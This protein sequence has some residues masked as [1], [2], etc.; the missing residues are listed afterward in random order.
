[1]NSVLDDSKLLTL[2]NGDRV[3]LTTTVR[4]LFEVQDLAVASPATV[5][6]A[7]M[8]YMDIEELGWKPFFEQWIVSKKETHGQDFADKLTELT[9][10]WLIKVLNI[11]K[12][13][14]RE[15]V[16]T[17]ENACTRSLSQLF[18]ACT[19]SLEKGEEESRE[20][21]LNYIEKWFVFAMI[22]SVGA[23]VDE[24]SRKDIDNVMRDI[25]AM[26]PH[27]NTV[28]EYYINEQKKDWAPWE[29]KL[30]SVIKPKGKEFH[31]IMV[32]TVDTVRNRYIC[33]RLVE[34]DS[35]ILFIG[36]SGVGKT[37]LIDGV[38]A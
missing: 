2:T 3:A 12:T 14:C 21:F 29:E 13:M 18:D 1:M 23:T 5:S 28:F 24:T 16:A 8:I 19:K 34:R 22:W 17:S 32:H 6:R 11:K 33:E 37:V 38:L 36:E 27:T 26:F 10:K 4:L 25:E 7:G 15:L 9:G 35:Q 31:E 20:D 30:S